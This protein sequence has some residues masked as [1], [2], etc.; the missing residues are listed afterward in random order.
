MTVPRD[1]DDH[2][3]LSWHKV[4][5]R[6]GKNTVKLARLKPLTFK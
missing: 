1:L 5:A 3:K 4:D 2:K 6:N